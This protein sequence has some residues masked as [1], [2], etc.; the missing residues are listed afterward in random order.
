ME[1]QA[2]FAATYHF[3]KTTVNIITP[4]NVT[5]EIK[6]KV[7]DEIH[8]IGWKI[9]RDEMKKKMEEHFKD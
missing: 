5:E 7:L 4:K 8:T 2:E 9:I 1:N 6:Q 3:G